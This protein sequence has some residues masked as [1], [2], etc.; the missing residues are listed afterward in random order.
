MRNRMPIKPMPVASSNRETLLD[1]SHRE[2]DK[3]ATMRAN[4]KKLYDKYGANR[5]KFV[6]HDNDKITWELKTL[7]DLFKNLK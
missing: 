5:V 3:L 1:T 4:R 2:E 6:V 7:D